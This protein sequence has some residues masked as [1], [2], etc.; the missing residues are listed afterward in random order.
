MK[1]GDKVKDLDAFEHFLEKMQRYFGKKLSAN[2]YKRL[3]TLYEDKRFTSELIESVIKYSKTYDRLHMRYIEKELEELLD[4]GITT[5]TQYRWLVD[6]VNVE[7]KLLKALGYREDLI[8]TQMRRYMDRWINEYKIA[9]DEL[10][11]L[12]EGARSKSMYP[13]IIEANERIEQFAKEQIIHELEVEI[14]KLRQENAALKVQI[15]AL[16]VAKDT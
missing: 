5:K 15:Q 6:T 4:K 8:T 1:W 3:K 11:R 7:K 13:N 16:E 9:L 10:I 14:S 12:C 2:E